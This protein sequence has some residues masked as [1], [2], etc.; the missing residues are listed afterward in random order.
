MTTARA[1]GLHALFSY[2]VSSKTGAGFDQL[3]Q[4]LTEQEAGCRPASHSSTVLHRGSVDTCAVGEC[5][6]TGGSAFASRSDG[7]KQACD[8]RC[9]CGR[10]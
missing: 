3:M 5:L 2:N 7:K 4:A 10:R 1:P 6:D 8:A 9:V